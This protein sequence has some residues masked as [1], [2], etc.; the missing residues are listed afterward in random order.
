MQ[1]N[2]ATYHT[3]SPTDPPTTP[4]RPMSR[5]LNPLHLGMMDLNQFLIICSLGPAHMYNLFFIIVLETR[6]PL[7]FCGAES[8]SASLAFRPR[9]ARS[10]KLVI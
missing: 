2:A 7:G 6:P 10:A 3:N 9:D 1:A 5:T 8:A 4:L